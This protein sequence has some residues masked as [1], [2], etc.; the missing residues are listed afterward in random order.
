MKNSFKINENFLCLISGVI[1]VCLL[2][3]GV[4]IYPQIE[5]ALRDAGF[6]ESE[7]SNDNYTNSTTSSLTNFNGLSF[8]GVSSEHNDPEQDK[9][10]SRIYSITLITNQVGKLIAGF[11]LD[12]YGFWLVKLL[13]I[14]FN[15]VGN[16]LMFL[17]TVYQ[18]D[19]LCYVAIP[20]QVSPTVIIVFLAVKM[21]CL[22]CKC[23]S[24][25]Y[26]GAQVT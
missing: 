9:A 24:A 25:S 2:V 23:F 22:K 6:F 14:G 17:V 18:V 13:V 15:S 7:N 26:L 10:F 3:Q 11:L 12:K 21:R 20:L 4:S 19:W 8:N 16:V 1:E 5:Y